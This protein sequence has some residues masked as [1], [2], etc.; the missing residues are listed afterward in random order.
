[1]PS[2]LAGAGNW[3]ASAAFASN[4]NGASAAFGFGGAGDGS[5]T[6]KKERR[7]K[8]NEPKVG[9]NSGNSGNGDNGEDNRRRKGDKHGLQ[10]PNSMKRRADGHG[11]IQNSD[12]AQSNDAYEVD[13]LPDSLV[14]GGS[15]NLSS[16]TTAS[17]HDQSRASDEYA[18]KIHNQLSADGIHPPAWPPNP[19]A[20][21]SKQAMARF[22]ETYEAY[23]SKARASLTRAG[24]IDDPNKRKRL[25]E[26]IPFKGICDEK[27]PQYEM[28]QRITEADV[29]SAERDKNGEDARLEYMVK[30]LARSAAGQEAPL[31]MD[32]RSTRALG[33]SLN[34][35]FRHVL[36]DE[37]N[38]RKVH[39]FV[40]DRTRAIR[41]DFAFFSSMLK[42]ETITQVY[43][44]EN[45]ARF[46]VAS[47]HLL[48]RQK[49][50]GESIEDVFSEHQE[51]EQLGKTLLSLRDVYDDCNE[52]NIQCD[53]EAEFRAYYLLFHGRDPAIVETLQLQ[54]NDRLWEESEEVR[55]ALTLVEVLHNSQ[56]FIGSSKHREDGPLL[57]AA[58]AYSSFF[59]I[60][61]SVAVS[62]TMACFAECHFPHIRRAILQSIKRAMWKPKP[63]MQDITA[64]ILNGFL[65]Y[66]TVDEAI[67]FAEKHGFEFSRSGSPSQ[68]TIIL[69]DRLPVPFVKIDHQFSQEL[70]EK[71]RG[72]WPLHEVLHRTVFERVGSSEYAPARQD[73][74]SLFVASDDES[75]QQM[76]QQKNAA[77]G[78]G[79][80]T[81]AKSAFGDAAGSH[82]KPRTMAPFV[83]ESASDPESDADL[84]KVP[85]RPETVTNNAVWGAPRFGQSGMPSDGAQAKQNPFGTIIKLP[86]M[87]QG[88]KQDGTAPIKPNPFATGSESKATVSASAGSQNPF[89]TFAA[90]KLGGLFSSDTNQ[91]SL[92]PT[93]PNP[94]AP[95]SAN[96]VSSL[97]G[98]KTTHQAS[99]DSNPFSGFGTLGNSGRTASDKI[100]PS[101]LAQSSQKSP[102]TPFPASLGK[103][104]LAGDGS[105]PSAITTTAN[106]ILPAPMKHAPI[107]SL[108]S[109]STFSASPSTAPSIPAFS[110]A[111]LPSAA[112]GVTLNSGPQV[113]TEVIKASRQASLT[114]LGAQSSPP[115]IPALPSTSAPQR[116]DKQDNIPSVLSEAAPALTSGIL[117]NANVAHSSLPQ[118]AADQSLLSQPATTPA[119]A[120]NASEKKGISISSGSGLFITKPEDSTL[121]VPPQP[122]PL[123]E[124]V[125]TS[126]PRRDLLGDFNR[127]FV[128]GDEGLLSEFLIES[129]TTI[130]RDAFEQ[131]EVEV[132]EK[133]RLEEIAKTNAEVE[134]FRVYNLSLKFF[135]RWKRNAREKRLRQ[136]RR[137]GR[138]EMRAFYAAR[139]AAESKARKETQEAE[140]D[141]K[142]GTGSSASVR[143]EFLS[144]IRS[145][146]KAKDDAAESLLASGILSGLNGE[147]EA[148]QAIVD[149]DFL[150]SGN[151][152]PASSVV[153]GLGRTRGSTQAAINGDEAEVRR[154][155]PIRAIRERF[156]GV[157]GGSALAP[158]KR[159]RYLDDD[160]IAKSGSVE[161]DPNKRVISD[162]STSR[163]A[164]NIETSPTNKRKRSIDEEERVTMDEGISHK[165]ILS[166]AAKVRLE[167]KALQA[168]LEE[169]AEWYRSQT[170]RFRSESEGRGASLFDESM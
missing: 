20:P 109:S 86:D 42:A 21:S 135:Y 159:K 142:V 62:Y 98:N 45:I 46:H 31:P 53:N 110:T 39:G 163:L 69:K 92:A 34:Y 136:V 164:G 143:S 75:T 105:S 71:K 48:P 79:L 133:T 161:G 160:G 2:T 134:K 13:D 66:D 80:E 154:L 24:L 19:G 41:R 88:L 139:S 49:Q 153:L 9:G 89:A 81:V 1:M 123:G 144:M 51:L 55:I 6:S 15:Y 106:S 112:G 17:F 52:Q 114:N 74:S 115:F 18:E 57:A 91:G 130:T 28:I 36:R 87:Q 149:G 94:F 124:K 67:E 30:K 12:P 146:K 127:W 61:H 121:S 122:L 111:H 4:G 16:S 116:V 37:S 126:S 3:S 47:L 10:G 128:M 68:W 77:V 118:G 54:W 27:C 103:P 58:S 104:V 162:S 97:F 117:G 64:E 167:L 70:V 65:R 169:G 156:R 145:K 93:K 22:R 151:A 8:R 11:S 85:T 90:Q 56:D 50:A 157:P 14:F 101:I 150:P 100:M 120:G 26:A 131:Y 33:V 35:L 7:K 59:D 32:V 60:V 84:P 107:T 170:G 43:V 96:S 76:Q 125:K 72:N 38:L 99:V 95:S 129:V 82:Q 141:C 119:S 40:W 83:L 23:R 138:D 165:R 140:K 102:T 147:R 63:P 168:E 155:S 152:R 148:V 5:V 158:G 44:L 25:S 78:P 137:Q 166:D 113:P 132:E 108:F 29:P 73:E